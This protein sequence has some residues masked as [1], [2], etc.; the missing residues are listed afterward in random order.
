MQGYHT[1]IHIMFTRIFNIKFK[2][3]FIPLSLITL[4]FILLAGQFAGCEPEDWS[5]QTDCNECYDYQPDSAK[6]IVYVTINAE[7]DSVALT[8]YRG[9]FEDGIIDWQDT[10]TTG[11][12]FL[13]SEIARE[14]SVRATYHSGAKTI[15]AFDQD[16]MRLSDN[17][18]E[19]GYPCYI[20]K[21]GI[22]DVTLP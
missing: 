4:A 16:K 20:V 15:I 22:F 7:Y 1:G 13:Y 11:E 10:A 17:G 5:L 3:G 12:F 14:Y 18:E 19:C 2:G 8:F 21:G 9:P 6:L